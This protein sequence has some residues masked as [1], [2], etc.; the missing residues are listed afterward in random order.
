[1]INNPPNNVELTRL[2][3]NIVTIR[4]PIEPGTDEDFID[5]ASMVTIF[6]SANELMLGSRIYDE[7]GKC[8]QCMMYAYNNCQMSGFKQEYEI[9]LSSGIEGIQIITAELDNFELTIH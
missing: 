2:N 3:N 4:K 7:N 8:V 1:M 9:A 6:D 5:G